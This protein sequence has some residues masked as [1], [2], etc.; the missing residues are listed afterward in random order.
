MSILK[1]ESTS[2][3]KEELALIVKFEVDIKIEAYIK[4]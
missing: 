4:V 3:P 2:N 1:I